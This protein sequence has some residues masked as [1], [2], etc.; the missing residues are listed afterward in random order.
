MREKT[1]R[2]KEIKTKPHN[3]HT[4]AKNCSK[5]M[6]SSSSIGRVPSVSGGII[7]FFTT[8]I[9]PWTSYNPSLWLKVASPNNEPGPRAAIQNKEKIE[10]S[11]NKSQ[12]G[13]KS[14]NYFHSAIINLLKRPAAHF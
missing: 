12:A 14:N 10:P 3:R 1:P 6:T 4:G 8:G 11:K 5:G 13:N 7:T 2:A 9:G